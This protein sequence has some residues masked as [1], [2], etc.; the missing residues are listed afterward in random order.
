MNILNFV[1]TILGLSLFE[2]INSVDNAV[3]NAEVLS[4]MSR[5]GRKWF[6]FWGILFAVFIIRGLL[7]WIIVWVTVPGLGPIGAITA[8]FSNDPAVSTAISQ[9]AP[10]L[11]SGAGI[12]LLFLFFHW[13]FVENKNFGLR[14]EAFFSRQSIWFYFVVSSVLAYIVWLS[15]KIN[16][17]LAFGAAIGASAFFL[18]EGFKESAE[19]QE[20]KLLKPGRSDLSKIFYLE[21]IDA[22]FSV[23]GVLGAFAFTLSVPTIILG[24]GL[25][26]F[27]LRQL[28]V[29]N[30]ER[31]KKYRFLKNGAM[32]SVFFLGLIMLLDALG[33]GIPSWI[34]PII[35]FLVVGYFFLRSRRN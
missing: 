30:I 20:K 15:L 28:T 35:T 14:H 17:H 18:V 16:P 26:A 2:I 1:L 24:N 8:T 13:L 19:K 31:I 23:D 34:S 22:A 29:G 7:P 25:G 21:V 33:A 6:L 4:T 12:F 3:I 11:L 10:I 5:R 32:Y 9:S 27:V